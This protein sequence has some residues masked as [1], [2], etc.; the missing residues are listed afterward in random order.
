LLQLDNLNRITG[1][2]HFQNEMIRD[3]QY[4]VIQTQQ[5]LG[6]QNP[7]AIPPS[8]LFVHLHEYP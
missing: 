1:M 2:L 3:A 7:S 8:L 6:S 5:R 4:I